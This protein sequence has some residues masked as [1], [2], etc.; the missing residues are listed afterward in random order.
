MAIWLL[1]IPI[2]STACSNS[3]TEMTA[4]STSIISGGIPVVNKADPGNLIIYSGRGELLV[5]PIIQ[6][7][8]DATSINI[9]VKYGQTQEIAA[10][11][12]EEGNKSP[13]DI[14]FASDPGGLGSVED[15]LAPLSNEILNLVPEWARSSKGKWVGLSGRARTVVYNPKNLTEADLPNDMY[16]FT[17]PKWKNRIGWAPTN[18]SFQTMVTA[19][20]AT[21]GEEKTRNW[22]EGIQANKPTTYPKNVPQLAAVAASEIDVGFVNHYYLY[23]FLA[24]EGETFSARNYHPSA[25]GPGSMVMVAGAGI[26]STSENPDNGQKFLQF[27][28]SKPAQQYFARQTFEYPLLEDIKTNPILTPLNEIKKPHVPVSKLADIRGTVNLL[29]ET[30]VLP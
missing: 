13:A 21:W 28:L 23:R 5:G 1:L 9:S 20:R 16:G 2:A 18:S 15:M 4:D 19:M 30:G 24:E 12:L 10:T 29:R 7:F 14:F 25:G 22:L 11:L 27:M 3:D 6:Q 17:D 26:L 8:Q